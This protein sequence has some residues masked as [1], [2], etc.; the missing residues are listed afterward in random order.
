MDTI[1][2]GK[3]TSS[4]DGPKALNADGTPGYSQTGGKL[5]YTKNAI[6]EALADSM[7]ELN[8]SRVESSSGSADVANS[9]IFTKQFQSFADRAV[10]RPEMHSDPS[11]WTS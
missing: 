4:N 5:A 6:A 7:R 9:S 8:N 2:N 3:A 1:T 10:S 11:S